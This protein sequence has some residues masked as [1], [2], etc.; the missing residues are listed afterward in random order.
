MLTPRT[1]QDGVASA[2]W[3]I[4]KCGVFLVVTGSA[5]TARPRAGAGTGQGQMPGVLRPHISAA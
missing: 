1:S 4:Y 2:K 3:E 5:G